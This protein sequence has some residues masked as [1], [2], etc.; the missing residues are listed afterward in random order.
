MARIYWEYW[1]NW[2]YWK[3]AHYVMRDEINGEDE[4]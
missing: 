3:N 4:I 2:E 1:E